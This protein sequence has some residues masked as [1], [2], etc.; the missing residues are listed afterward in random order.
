VLRIDR[1]VTPLDRKELWCRGYSE[2]S[3]RRRS[4][5][6]QGAV[7]A[8]WSRSDSYQG[9]PPDVTSGVQA[10]R[11]LGPHGTQVTVSEN[12]PGWRRRSKSSQNG[13]IGGNFYTSKTSA[14]M[15]GGRVS[16]SKG[17]RIF[18][19]V[20]TEKYNGYLLP[21]GPS[22]QM[23]PDASSS[24]GAITQYGTKAIAAVKPTNALADLATA[25]SELIKDG[26]PQTIGREL[27][28]S[29]TRRAYLHATGSEYLN[30]EF[31][32]KPMLAD[33][34]KTM[35]AMVRADTVMRQYKRDA[36]R[37]VR[38]RYDFPTYKNREFTLI[39]SG[40]NAVV[41]YSTGAWA[42]SPGLTGQV[43]RQ[44]DT[45]IERWFSGCFTYHLPFTPSGEEHISKAKLF[46]LD[47]KPSTL[48][49]LAP[50]SWA[51]DWFVPVGD[52]IS[53]LEDWAQD[54][55]VLQ[56]GYMMEHASVTD[57]Y[58]FQG[59]TGYTFSDRPGVYVLQNVT[60]KRIRA[61]P[62]GFGLSWSGLTS[63]QLAIAAALGLSQSGRS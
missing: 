42:S 4:V 5:P 48:W 34:N 45:L 20:R 26:A 12:H 23:P 28:E 24:D 27:W 54:G 55:L 21:F 15:N 43:L 32:W 18:D 33:I 51:V 17:S 49:N 6:F 53:N 46:G 62:F 11:P 44:R 25:L 60:K 16:W 56:Y 38:R 59:D 14:V 10:P 61:N 19:I 2:M 7:G 58:T 9:Q 47:I 63:R 31:G 22:P 29:T 40:V 52:V 1:G 57:T 36:G 50:W 8:K 13:D 35:A 3:T 41:G 39:S 30:V 37:P